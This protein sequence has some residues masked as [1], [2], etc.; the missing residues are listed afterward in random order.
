MNGNR[1]WV[2]KKERN[3]KRAKKKP[4]YEKEIPYFFL[5]IILEKLDARGRASG[6]NVPHG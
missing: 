5:P 2:R 3:E 1:R 4:Y 6:A